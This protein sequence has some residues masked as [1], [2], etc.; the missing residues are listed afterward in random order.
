M[1]DIRSVS[2]QVINKTIELDYKTGI[3]D[4]YMLLNILLGQYAFET[5]YISEMINLARAGQIHSGVQ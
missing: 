2:N 3:Q 5:N 4:S 1:G